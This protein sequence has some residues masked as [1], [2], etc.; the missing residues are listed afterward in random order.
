MNITGIMHVSFYTDQLD[1]MRDFYENKLG[2][3]P[4]IVTKAIAYKG[5]KNY[6]GEIAEIDPEKIVIV[7]D[8]IISGQY[9][10]LFPKKPNQK[11]KEPANYRL[12]YAHFSLLVDDIFEAKEELL[13]KGI[14][15]DTDITK[16][17]SETYKLW[18]HD[19]DGN[20]IEI[21]Q[22][23]EKSYQIVGNIM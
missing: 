11:A 1:K 3:K 5:R 16:G 22:F 10:E 23:T 8:E 9:I 15:L 7:Y 13:K 12:G 20:M 6:F 14:E 4:K 19:P 21:M 18:I 2:F 17:P